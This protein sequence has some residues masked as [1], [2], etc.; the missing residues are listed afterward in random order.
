ALETA[1]PDPWAIPDGWRLGDRAWTTWRFTHGAGA[2][3]AVRVR[4]RAADA[5]VAVAADPSGVPC[6]GAYSGRRL[7]VRFGGRRISFAVAR[8]GEMLWLGTGGRTWV[9]TDHVPERLG[10]AVS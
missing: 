9:L 2:P 3:V 1:D 4:G 8:D 6:R 5:V 7:E 10:A